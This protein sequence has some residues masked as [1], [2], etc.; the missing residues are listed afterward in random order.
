[1]KHLLEDHPTVEYW[2]CQACN[3]LVQYDQESF[4]VHLARYHQ[5]HEEHFPGLLID[6]KRKVPEEVKSCPICDWPNGKE[7]DRQDLIDHIAEGIF[8]FSLRSFPWVQDEDNS[9]IGH[10]GYFTAKILDWL[11]M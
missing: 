9:N 7:V 4:L 11:K 2:V 1:M 6:G 10:M 8:A 5:G 3:D